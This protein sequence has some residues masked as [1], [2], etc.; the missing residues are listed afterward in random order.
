M[1]GNQQDNIF[2]YKF[3]NDRMILLLFR[4]RYKML[5]GGDCTEIYKY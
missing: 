2:K 3:G 1:K 5:I 4:Y